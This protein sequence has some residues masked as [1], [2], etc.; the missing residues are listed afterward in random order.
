MNCEYC[1]TRNAEDEP[2][3]IRCGRRLRAASTA[4][5]SYPASRVSSALAMERE[6]VIVEDP[7][8]LRTPIPHKLSFSEEPAPKVIPFESFAAHRIQPIPGA[9]AEPREVLTPPPAGPKPQAYKPTDRRRP[10]APT[11]DE[12]QSDLDFLVPPP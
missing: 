3:C 12:R 8:P 11:K 7:S 1:R 6:Q 5:P 9:I 4:V 10:A 2:R